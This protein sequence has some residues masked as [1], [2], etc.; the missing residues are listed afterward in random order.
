M[1]DLPEVV[2][3][4]VAHEKFSFTPPPDFGAASRM[5]ID[6]GL[7]FFLAPLLGGEGQAYRRGFLARKKTA[8]SVTIGGAIQ[9]SGGAMRGMVI[10]L[11]FRIHGKWIRNESR[12]EIDC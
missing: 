12:S 4:P 2:F 5:P 8:D 3:P 9:V 1:L 7:G 11:F 6:P 10:I